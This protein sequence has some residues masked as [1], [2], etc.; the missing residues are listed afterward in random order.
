MA[1]MDQ[2]MPTLETIMQEVEQY[3]E[4]EKVSFETFKAFAVPKL[5]LSELPRSSTHHRRHFATFVFLSALLVGSRPR[6]RQP[7]FGQSRND[8]HRRSNEPTAQACLEAHQEEHRKRQRAVDDAHR[9]VHAANHH[10]QFRG[11]AQRSVPAARREGQEEG[12]QHV[13]QGR[14][15]AGFLE[16]V[17]RRHFADRIAD[18]RR[19]A[20][21][22]PRHL[23]VLSTADQIRRLAAQPLAE[24]QYSRGRRALQQRRRDIQHLVEEHVL[25]KGG[26]ELHQRERDRQHGADHADS[27]T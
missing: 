26:T 12:R 14:E 24:E 6:Q 8:G 23:L 4:S 25:P 3:V 5:I 13:P 22:G 21:A 18:S 7:N 11:A 16:V 1:K 10:Q 20:I 19:L 2:T 27:L 9:S 17:Q 15:L